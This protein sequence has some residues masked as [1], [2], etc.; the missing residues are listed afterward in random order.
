MAG[1]D[2]TLIVGETGS[3]DPN[4]DRVQEAV[5]S[6]AQEKGWRPIDQW[7]GDPADW[8]DAKEFLGRQSLFDKISNLKSELQ[9]QRRAFDNDMKNI[10]AYI[11]QMSEVEY[12]RAL[13]E[14]K[15]QKRVAIDDRDADAVEQI[16]K[17]IQ[18]VEESR[19]TVKAQTQQPVD[20]RE[21]QEKFAEW[22]GR[23]Q[24]Y[25]QDTELKEE[26]DQIGIGY[27][28]KH[29]NA[30]V[31]QVFAH[32]EKQI[33]KLFPEKFGGSTKVSDTTSNAP[34]VEGGGINKNS[35]P[36]PRTDRLTEADLTPPQ[37]NMMQSMLRQKLMTKEQFLSQ[38]ED[39]LT[40]NHR[41]FN[42]YTKKDGG[43]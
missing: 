8:V 34:A 7:Q 33:K 16:D 9:S 20:N 4:P 18:T 39:A 6:K 35:N 26:A 10:K 25:V 3:H 24:W 15:S 43:K 17:Q 29:P 42:E 14:L 13:R 12:Q 11:S 28:A 22:K 27:G 5:I 32:V 31:E 1:E 40:G 21:V 36:R 23:N 37:R 41:P 30:S 38:M 19:A 2:G